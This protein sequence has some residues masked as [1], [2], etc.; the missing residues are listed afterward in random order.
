MLNVKE[1][2][3]S[4]YSFQSVCKDGGK[5]TGIHRRLPPVPGFPATGPAGNSRTIPFQYKILQ[6]STQ[7]FQISVR[8]RKPAFSNVFFQEF[9]SS[10]SIFRFP[11]FQKAGLKIF[12]IEKLHILVV[13][14][15]P[16]L[17]K[18][19]KNAEFLQKN[20]FK[21]YIDFLLFDRYTE[22]VLD[23]SILVYQLL[24]FIVMNRLGGNI[25]KIGLRALS[26]RLRFG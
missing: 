25:W 1:A 21:S 26:E 13:Y 8:P 14:Y 23:T 19:R 12:L 18:N 24:R 5:H 4:A 3:F 11:A 9:S 20:I 15:S 6:R 22:N 2:V 10:L 16:F 17:L 7:V